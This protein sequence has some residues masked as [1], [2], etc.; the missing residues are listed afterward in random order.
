MINVKTELGILSV[1]KTIDG[2][3]N[4][5]H[6]G[7]WSVFVRT[8][9]CTV[10]CHWCDTKYSWSA[11]GGA[12]FLPP[13]L[14]EVVKHVGGGIHKVTLTGGEP[15]EQDWVGL[16]LFIKL[17]I[18]ED[19]LITVETAG[20]QD[21]IQ[22]RNGLEDMLLFRPPFGMLTFVVDWKLP[23]S[24][25]KGNMD[26]QHFSHLQHGDVVKFV[27]DTTE[28]FNEACKVA[29]LLYDKRT[30]GA[31]MYFSPAHGMMTPVRLF[32]MMIVAGMPNI[33]VGINLQMHKYIWP[34]DVRAEENYGVDFTKRTLGREE[35]LRRIREREGA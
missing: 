19:Y 24:K 18:E 32:R 12:R 4:L 20:T 23:S 33:G 28:D 7:N 10:G 35:Y 17:L 1:Y 3:A 11:K 16:Y 9:G 5:W 27:I 31:R 14:V 34:I 22:F 2:E 26:L 15:L 13:E 25:F 21:T 30:F 6:Q 29:R 8:A